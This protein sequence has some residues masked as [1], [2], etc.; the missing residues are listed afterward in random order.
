M[1]SIIIEANLVNFP[2]FTIMMCSI[3][4]MFMSMSFRKKNN[5]R[6]I[7]NYLRIIK[8]TPHVCDMYVSIQNVKRKLTIILD[9]KGKS[10]GVFL[11]PS[12]GKNATNFFSYLIIHLQ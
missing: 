9:K 1:K 4:S 7:K 10:R 11:M 6:I 12:N 5:L 3:M 2:R 8:Y